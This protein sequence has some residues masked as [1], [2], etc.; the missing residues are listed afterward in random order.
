MDPLAFRLAAA[1]AA[2]MAISWLVDRGAERRGLLPP[3]FAVPW[4]IAALLGGTILLVGSGVAYAVG[5]FGAS[6]PADREE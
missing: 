1:L 3:G 6:V 4:R 2:A 5:Y